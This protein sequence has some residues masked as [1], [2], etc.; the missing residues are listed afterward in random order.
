M[1]GMTQISFLFRNLFL[2]I[3]NYQSGMAK[4]IQ[5]LVLKHLIEITQL[6]IEDFTC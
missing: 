1:D 2:S 6:L 3:S 5:Y 4:K